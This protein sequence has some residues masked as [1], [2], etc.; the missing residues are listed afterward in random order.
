MIKK[1]LT[2]KIFI[3]IVEITVIGGFVTTVVVLNTKRKQVSEVSTSTIET[4]KQEESINEGNNIE[5]KLDEAE[6]K[7]AQLEEKTNELE[8]TQKDEQ[9]A[10]NENIEKK[11]TTISSN[12]STTQ[13]NNTKTETKTQ[14][15]QHMTST[16]VTQE[17][18]NPSTQSPTTQSNTSIQANNESNNIQQKN[19]G[20][21][22]IKSSNIMNEYI[23]GYVWNDEKPD[24][25]E[26]KVI[27]GINNIYT[28]IINKETE[29]II[30]DVKGENTD[31]VKIYVDKLLFKGKTYKLDFTQDNPT[32]IIE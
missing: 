8:N 13:S 5:E 25:I 3:I 16:S 23:T 7:I 29:D 32:L 10:N 11:Q 28:G 15:T 9:T 17:V 22:I 2:S 30:L 21:I 19:D 24:S 18:Q 12:K 27:F 6:N 1:I 4:K 26:L 20:K 14:N 31:I